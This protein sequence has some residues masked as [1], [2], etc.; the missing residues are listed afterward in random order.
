[1][2]AADCFDENKVGNAEQKCRVIPNALIQFHN[3][4]NVSLYV[5]LV[6]HVRRLRL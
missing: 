5:E 4:D 6:S 2:K 3:E 1:M